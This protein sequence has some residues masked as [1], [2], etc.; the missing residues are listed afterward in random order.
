MSDAK[1]RHKHRHY[2]KTLSIKLCLVED[3]VA[4]IIPG[5]E[6]VQMVGDMVHM[7][8][9]TAPI[10]RGE[11]AHLSGPLSLPLPNQYYFFVLTTLSLFC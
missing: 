1:L 4:K 10:S 2:N 3:M 6:A 5:E 9:E 7:V 11:L 8:E